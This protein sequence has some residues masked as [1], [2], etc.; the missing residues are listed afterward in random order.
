MIEKAKSNVAKYGYKNV[1]FKLG[2]IEDLPI[3]DNSIDVVISN[4]VIN[5]APDKSQVF[6]EAYRVLKKTGKMFVSDIVL[7]E[8]L[9]KEQKNNPDLL[10]GCVAGALQK[11]DY[12]KIVKKVGFKVRILGED[13]E[14]KHMLEEFNGHELMKQVGRVKVDFKSNSFP[15][16]ILIVDYHNFLLFLCKT[17]KFKPIP[18]KK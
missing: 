7:L 1:E 4:C 2:E 11:E 13:K 15:S 3:E 10:S 12:L 17:G 5:L 8:E 6:K 14:I 18:P 9:T 16:R